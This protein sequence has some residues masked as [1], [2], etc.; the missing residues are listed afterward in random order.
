MRSPADRLRTP[1]EHTR[2]RWL[3]R[4]RGNQND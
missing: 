4:E 3:A 1:V 2:T